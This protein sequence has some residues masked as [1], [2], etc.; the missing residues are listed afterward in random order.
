MLLKK[1]SYQYL[2]FFLQNLTLQVQLL[3]FYSRYLKQNLTRSIL[4][5]NSFTVVQH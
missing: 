2:L 4:D 1:Y 5:T 3:I